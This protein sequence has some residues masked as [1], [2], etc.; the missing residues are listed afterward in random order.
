MPLI[1]HRV[2]REGTPRS[3]R[4]AAKPKHLS[5]RIEFEWH[6]ILP[7]PLGEC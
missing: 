3:G 7:S 1:N 6:P 5:G 4:A 2:N